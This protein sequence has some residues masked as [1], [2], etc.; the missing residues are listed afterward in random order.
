MAFLGIGK[1]KETASQTDMSLEGLD[2]SEQENPQDYPQQPWQ[3]YEQ[4]QPQDYQQ[5]QYP[6]GTPQS[7]QQQM[8]QFQPP[9]PPEMSQGRIEEVAEAIVEEKWMEKKKEIDKVMEWKEEM[10]TKLIQL[11]QQID[12]LKSSFDSLHKGLLGK[13][14]EYDENLTSV[15]TEIKAMEKVFS[16]VLPSFTESVNK[17]Q[18]IADTDTKKK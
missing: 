18:R 15:G 8:P 6:S 9:P 1:K 11:Q 3:N 12:D 7:L 16:K 4:Y 13:I 17:L 10:T 2:N 14:S 5:Q